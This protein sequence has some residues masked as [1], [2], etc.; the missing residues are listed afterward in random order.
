MEE[1]EPVVVRMRTVIRAEEASMTGFVV[2]PDGDA[3]P[4]IWECLQAA[5][6]IVVSMEGFRV[7]RPGHVTCLRC[8]RPMR[9]SGATL[10]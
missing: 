5:C 3:I 8:L 2:A 7:V 1:P 4:I 9:L 10:H 6:P